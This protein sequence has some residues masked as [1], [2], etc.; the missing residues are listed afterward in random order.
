MLDISVLFFNIFLEFVLTF[1]SYVNKFLNAG[2][3]ERC[4]LLFKTLTND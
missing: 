2:C 4:W 1:V 3:K